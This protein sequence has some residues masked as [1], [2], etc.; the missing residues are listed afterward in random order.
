MTVSSGGQPGNPQATSETR[1]AASLG[2]RKRSR[3]HHFIRSAAAASSGRTFLEDLIVLRA[4]TFSYLRKRHHAREI[5]LDPCGSARK[6]GLH[7]EVSASGPEGTGSGENRS[8]R[9]RNPG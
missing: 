2:S 7:Q 4:M 1:M 6:S 3:V 9:D 8:E 5:A